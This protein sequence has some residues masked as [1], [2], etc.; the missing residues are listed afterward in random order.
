[1]NDKLVKSTFL[2]LCRYEL[3]RNFISVLPEFNTISNYDWDSLQTPKDRV[4]TQNA[5]CSLIVSLPVQATTAIQAFV[6]ANPAFQGVLFAIEKMAAEFSIKTASEPANAMHR[7]AFALK[8]ISLLSEILFRVRLLDFDPVYLKSLIEMAISKKFRLGPFYNSIIAIMND[9]TLTQ[10]DIAYKIYGLA[11][12]VID[13]ELVGGKE[14][15]IKLNKIM[16]DENPLYT[17]FDRV[18]VIN[19]DRRKDRWDALQ[20]KLAHIKWPF[21]APERF[22]AYDG[23]VMPMPVGWNDGEGTWGCLLSHREVLGQAIKDK[24]ENVLVLEDDIFFSDTF[25]SDIVK[26]IKEIPFDWDQIM[27]GGQ[28]FDTTK[29]YDI[30]DNILKVSLC[31]RAHAYAVRGDYM[32]Y[33]YSKLNS[34]YGHVDH[35]MNTFQDRY[36]VYTPKYFLIGQD[37]SSSDISGATDSVS[38]MRNVPEKDTPIF[39]VNKDLALL[40]QVI[41]SGLPLHYG[42]LDN[43]GQNKGLAEIN[44]KHSAQLSKTKTQCLYDLNNFLISGIWYARSVYPS[45]YFT[46]MNVKD[47]LVPEIIESSAKLNLVVV[48]SVE[49]IKEII[50]KHAF[51]ET[52]S[53]KFAEHQQEL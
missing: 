6:T 31:H 14:Y 4:V 8:K 40:D 33:V 2:E 12:N 53:T 19:L 10:S 44:G 28:Y 52:L 21:R 26:F 35:I 11:A 27:L 25:D 47:Y 15:Y 37:G 16:S 20:E 51:G 42:P 46:I 1:M 49:Q 17:F 29:A 50:S 36:N 30:S 9:T 43:E 22:A 32:K 38:L 48:E 5:I 18:V 39:L 3:F 34:T 45:K 7:K 41:N 23:K 24:L 13:S